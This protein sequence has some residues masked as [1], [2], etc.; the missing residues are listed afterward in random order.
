[1]TGLILTLRIDCIQLFG[2]L[3]CG[4]CCC[5]C[6]CCCFS[7]NS[8]F[9]FTKFSRA[10]H[11]MNGQLC[12]NNR[13]GARKK[14]VRKHEQKLKSRLK[15]YYCCWLFLVNGFNRSSPFPLLQFVLCLCMHTRLL[16]VGLMPHPLLFWSEHAKFLTLDVLCACNKKIRY[17]NVLG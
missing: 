13:G 2:T 16:I 1:M 5:C 17:S 7:M 4:C 10:I 9:L 8:R 12:G 11:M 14:N 3:N 6:R 15:Y